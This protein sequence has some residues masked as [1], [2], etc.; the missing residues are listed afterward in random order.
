MNNAAGAVLQIIAV[1]VGMLGD[2]AAAVKIV[3]RAVR[4]G[5]REIR[6]GRFIIIDGKAD[7]VKMH[8]HQR[9]GGP[10]GQRII[11]ADRIRRS[12]DAQLT[13]AN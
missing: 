5:E 12:S 3:G 4:R 1:A 8:R 6:R 11:H 10:A 9:G 2:I 7:V 13:L